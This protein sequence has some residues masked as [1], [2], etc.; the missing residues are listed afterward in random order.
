MAPNKCRRLNITSRPN[1][2]FKI[3]HFKLES[4]KYIELSKVEQNIH[5]IYFVINQLTK[6][7]MGCCSLDKIF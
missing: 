1:F 2:V 5:N 4:K 6:N 7:S 3:K